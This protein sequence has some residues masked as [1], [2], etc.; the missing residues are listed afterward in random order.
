MAVNTFK[1]NT[2]TFEAGAEYSAVINFENSQRLFGAILPDAWEEADLALQ[3]SVDDGDNWH[4]VRKRTGIVSIEGF[5]GDCNLVDSP[6]GLA[7]FP[8]FRLRSVTKADRTVGI[9]QTVEQVVKLAC[10]SYE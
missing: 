10:R 6:V 1:E 4:N 7:A 2:V 3:I 8:A 9:A 5:A